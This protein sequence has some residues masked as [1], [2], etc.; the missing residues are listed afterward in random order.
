[1]ILKFSFGLRRGNFVQLQLFKRYLRL[2]VDSKLHNNN[3][4]KN[5]YVYLFI[6][7]N[8]NRNS[9]SSKVETY[10]ILSKDIC[11]N[12][13][14]SSHRPNMRLKHAT[15]CCSDDDQIPDSSS[16]DQFSDFSDNIGISGTSDEKILGVC[17]LSVAFIVD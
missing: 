8:R 3:C 11:I 13:P 6:P 7:W 1:M 12:F 10:L 14:V 16:D 2:F 4:Y 15:F 9:P 17:L 5:I